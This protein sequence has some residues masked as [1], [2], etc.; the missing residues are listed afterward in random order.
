M[1]PNAVLEEALRA[2]REVDQ[3]KYPQKLRFGFKDVDFD[4]TEKDSTSKPSV[5]RVLS[6]D[7]GAGSESSSGNYNNGSISC[8]TVRHPPF[9]QETPITHNITTLKTE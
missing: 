4:R 1:Q 9:N 3:A 2:W 7:I 8:S 5:V 6:F